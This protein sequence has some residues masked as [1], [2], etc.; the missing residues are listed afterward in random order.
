MGDGIERL[1]EIQ[2]CHVYLGSKVE[3]RE[4]VMHGG[5]ALNDLMDLSNLHTPA[6]FMLYL[7][8]GYAG[9]LGCWGAAVL[10]CCGGSKCGGA[11]PSSLVKTLW[12]YSNI[13][14]AFSL[15]SKL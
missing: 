7:Y 8:V 3:G 15:L 4:K 5:Q 9:V 13:I 6:V 14:C 10:R 1:A 2:Y 12:N 11:D